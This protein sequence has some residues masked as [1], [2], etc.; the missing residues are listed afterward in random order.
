MPAEPQGEDAMAE[1]EEIAQLVRDLTE[2]KAAVG[3]NRAILREMVEGK[4]FELY[5]LVTGVAIAT[6]SLLFVGAADRY[7]SVSAAP[8]VLRLGLCLLVAFASIGIVLW[9]WLV[10]RKAA[11]RIDL[12]LM[13]W[14]VIGGFYR[15]S[16]LPALLPMLLVTGGA[17]AYLLIT[18][19]AY[20]VIG[21]VAIAAGIMLNDVSSRLRTREYYFFGFWLFA[22][23]AASLFLNRIPGGVWCAIS[24]GGA[25]L[26][27]VVATE[28][29]KWARGSRK[30][31][32]E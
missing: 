2:I 8:L 21:T 11:S 29:L 30:R 15:E 5:I 14:S 26:A 19:H 27:F 10:L 1:R 31:E 17:I 28:I 23:G 3:R 25:C 18:R 16:F 13:P 32:R 7:G 22:S 24:F 4:N 20:F 12:K 6:I 9:K